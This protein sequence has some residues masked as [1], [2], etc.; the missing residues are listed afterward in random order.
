MDLAFNLLLTILVELPIIGFF[1]RKR[2]RRPALMLG[3]MVNVVT[4][5]IA[6]IIRLNT[7][8]NLNYVEIG[9]V[10]FE[11]IAYWLF[12]GRNVKRA[13]LITLAANAAS[14]IITKFVHISP[15]FFQKKTNIIR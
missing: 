3:L 1:F 7:E 2:K 8:W 6:N 13:V 11:G 15:D 12:L 4:W 14:F 10:I 9:V 5:P